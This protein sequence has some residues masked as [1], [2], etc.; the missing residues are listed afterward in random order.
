MIH[1]FLTN[2]GSKAKTIRPLG[3]ALVGAL[4]GSFGCGRPSSSPEEKP[5]LP[6]KW[7]E[8]I[9]SPSVTAVRTYVEALAK[10]G[11]DNTHRAS[12]S[13]GYQQSV[14]YVLS[15]LPS[16][17]TTEQQSFSYK[18]LKVKTLEL[19][20]QS[21]TPQG[22]RGSPRNAPIQPVA[23]TSKFLSLSSRARDK[24]DLGRKLNGLIVPAAPQ[25]GPYPELLGVDQLGPV[26]FELQPRLLRPAAGCQTS[27]FAMVRSLRKEGKGNLAAVVAEGRCP[28]EVKAER[29]AA[30]GAAALFVLSSRPHSCLGHSL[31]EQN[32]LDAGGKWPKGSRVANSSEHIP[33][34]TVDR[35]WWQQQLSALGPLPKAPA[36]SLTLAEEAVTTQNVIARYSAL[37]Q[38]SSGSAA[39]GNTFILGA[40][41]DSVAAGPGINDNV[42]G[43]AVL[44]SLA[45]AIAQQQPQM[46]QSL[47]LIFWGAEEDGLKGSR[48]YVQNLTEE[49]ISKISGYLNLDMVGSPNYGRFIYGNSGSN[50]V[51]DALAGYYLQEGLGTEAIIVGERSDHFAFQQA[52]VS[53]AGLYTGGSEIKS[54]AQARAF[55]G[56]SGKSFDS[57]YHEACDTLSNISNDVLL[58]SYRAA[59]HTAAIL[60]GGSSSKGR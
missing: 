34:Y 52:G 45:D 12:G 42:S 21:L 43:V 6:P 13:E 22:L 9:T 32:R 5:A 51:R 48:H 3:L 41:L 58:E 55:G 20:G 27:D 15:A 46:N 16:G 36:I 24:S 30:E 60:I 56:E 4:T 17:F 31:Q 2:L 39:E 40:H 44:L 8:V 11:T 37:E 53:V 19:A 47:T 57:C 35:Q 54:S 23:G 59:A 7:Q 10:I 28:L 26:E 1:Y 49:Q 29:A 50:R 38:D 18:S 25:V 14:S 33:I